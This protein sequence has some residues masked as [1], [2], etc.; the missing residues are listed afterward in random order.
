M[1][2]NLNISPPYLPQPPSII[3]PFCPSKHTFR[4]L[5]LSSSLYH[6]RSFKT[7]ASSS[8][9]EIEK[10]P[11]S[12]LLNDDE[13]LTRIS[14]VKDADE[15]LLVIAEKSQRSGGTVSS[16]DCALVIKA[17]FDRNNIELALSVYSAMRTSFNQG[18]HIRANA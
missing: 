15:A 10:P 7:K 1:A 3:S 6:L 9:R 4:N 17:A 18:I 16:S 8:N 5:L 11:V 14:S 2:L 13:L 12:E